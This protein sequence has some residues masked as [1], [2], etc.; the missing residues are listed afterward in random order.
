MT[1][2]K[3]LR[4]GLHRKCLREAARRREERSERLSH[5]VNLQFYTRSLIL[6]AK[7]GMIDDFQLTADE[8]DSLFYHA[9]VEM[10]GG[11]GRK[12]K[13]ILDPYNEILKN[14]EK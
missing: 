9:I 11:R 4:E 5:A 7:I 2:Q 13:V 12:K 10:H 14:E 8:V 1:S 6:S 3:K